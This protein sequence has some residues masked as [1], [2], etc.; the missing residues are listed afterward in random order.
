MKKITLV[1]IGL[2]TL[3]ALLAFAGHIHHGSYCP[4]G[5][6]TLTFCATTITGHN[7]DGYIEIDEKYTGC[8]VALW[9]KNCL[10]HEGND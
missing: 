8:T 9:C 5:D 3:M 10:I 4:C 6:N 2:S 7:Y 1:A